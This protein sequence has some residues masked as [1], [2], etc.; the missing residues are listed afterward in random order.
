MKPAAII[1]GILSVVIS[2]TG[3]SFWEDLPVKDVEET[4]TT[5]TAREHSGGMVLVKAKDSSFAMGSTLDDNAKPVHTVRFTYDFWMDTTEVTQGSYDSVMKAGYPGFTVNEWDPQYG[6]GSSF[7]V[8][9]RTWYD[10]VLFCNAVSKKSG[11]DTV[12]CF[13][14]VSGD[15]G[16]GCE[17]RITSIDTQGIGYRLPTEA[18][19]EYACRGGTTTEYYWGNGTV[20]DYAWFRTNANNSSHP[21]SKKKPNSF[22]LYD[23]SGNVAEWCVDLYGGTYPDSTVTNPVVL[24][25]SIFKKRVNRGGS[26]DTD[27]VGIS[28]VV[29]DAVYPIPQDQFP[30]VK[31]GFRTV[32]KKS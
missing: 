22:G 27:L 19:W 25:G 17:L 16:N 2:M 32:R 31:I 28:S 30:Y 12:Y 18:E 23:L 29:R 13:D 6:K 11:L 7:P 24:S 5:T 1:T 4:D 9:G 20:Q 15:L 8:F 14:T 10:A 21:V 26:W 3:C